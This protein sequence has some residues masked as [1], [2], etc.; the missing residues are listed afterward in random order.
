[1]NENNELADILDDLKEEL[2]LIKKRLPKLGLSYWDFA[3]LIGLIIAIGAAIVG[4]VVTSPV[5]VTVAAVV[6]IIATI[7]SLLGFAVDEAQE[8]GTKE[9]LRERVNSLEKLK[10][11]LEQA[12][13]ETRE[14]AQPRSL[15]QPIEHAPA[16]S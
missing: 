5:I 15:N 7:A 14:K 16:T 1:M 3:V 4:I 8:Q 6:G 2:E 12:V 13:P 9:E 11:R 10:E